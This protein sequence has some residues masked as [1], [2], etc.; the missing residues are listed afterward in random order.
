MLRVGDGAGVDTVPCALAMGEGVGLE[1]GAGVDLEDDAANLPETSAGTEVWPFLG[2]SK[3][4]DDDDADALLFKAA[5]DD[6]V[7]TG[8]VF[9][10][11]DI[12]DGVLRCE[13]VDADES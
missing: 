6:L 5:D 8:E 3:V 13:G 12:R 1:V 9:E 10:G 7:G 4:E 11:V 2:G